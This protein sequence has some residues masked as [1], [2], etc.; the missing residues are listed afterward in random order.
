[1][2]EASC[3]CGAVRVALARAPDELTECNC[4]IC[5]RLGALWAYYDPWEV[6]VSAADD[7]L[8]GYIREQRLLRFCHCRHCGCT[9][10]WEAF[11]PEV[12]RMGVNARLLDPE[13][14]DDAHIRHIDGAD[15]WEY[16]DEDPL[17]PDG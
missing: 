12:R 17:R 13:I 14:V 1:M 4:S 7:A 10:H 5:R 2:I 3:H 16:L 9:T 11:D 8:G 15:S 6:T